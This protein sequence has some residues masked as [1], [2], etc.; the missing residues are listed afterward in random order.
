[1]P[2]AT[3]TNIDFNFTTRTGKKCV[4]LETLADP[5]KGKPKEPRQHML[6]PAYKQDLIDQVKEL[7]VGDRI[8]YTVDDSQYKNIESFWKLTVENSQGSAG[9]RTGSTFNPQPINE[10]KSKSIAR[11]VAIKAGVDIVGKMLQ[12][13]N[14]KFIKKTIETE[15]IGDEVLKLAKQ[16]EPYL[17]IEDGPVQAP[18]DN[19]SGAD[20]QDFNQEGFGGT[21]E[22]VPF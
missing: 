3:V 20:N 5:Y 21:R 10:D 22:D 17:M 19:L 8:E 6:F 18:D 11:A 7:S 1:M 13:G 15:L 14:G 2:K 9:P 12:S 16:F 4:M